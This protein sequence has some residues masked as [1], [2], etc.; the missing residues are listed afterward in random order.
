MN[1][2]KPENFAQLLLGET[3]WQLTQEATEQTEHGPSQSVPSSNEKELVIKALGEYAHEKLEKEGKL[4]FFGGEIEKKKK[5][6]DIFETRFSSFDEWFKQ[7][8]LQTSSRPNQGLKVLF[9]T[10]NEPYTEEVLDG[11]NRLSAFA[12]KSAELFIKM[13]AALNISAQEYCLLSYQHISQESFKEA[14]FWIKPQLVVSFGANSAK[15]ACQTQLRLTQIHG[16]EFT[17]EFEKFSIKVIPLFHPS[18][19]LN[20][21]NMK[22]TTWTDMQK[23]LKLLD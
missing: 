19:L 12:K 10:E 17:R 1:T 15:T 2:Q 4:S 13:R 5:N 20:N 14:L 22:K 11:V 3:P 23:I 8:A 18:I 9:L 6:E 7:T 21:L 16:K